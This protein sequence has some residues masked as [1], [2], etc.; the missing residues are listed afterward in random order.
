MGENNQKQRAVQ[1]KTIY[2]RCWT[3]DENS[4]ENINV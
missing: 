2:I 1:K 3:R 4:K